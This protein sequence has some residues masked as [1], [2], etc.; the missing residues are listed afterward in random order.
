M[1]S[2]RH[3]GFE[4]TLDFSLMLLFFQGLPY[5]SDQTGGGYVFPVK[6]P[7][8]FFIVNNSFIASFPVFL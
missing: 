5:G 8:R 7:T 3:N 6:S 1:I 2:S 4:V